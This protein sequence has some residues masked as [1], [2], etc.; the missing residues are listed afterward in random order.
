MGARPAGRF[1]AC[2]DFIPTACVHNLMTG[3]DLPLNLDVG[4]EVVASGHM[5]RIWEEDD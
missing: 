1:S 4:R 5:V 3:G 2:N